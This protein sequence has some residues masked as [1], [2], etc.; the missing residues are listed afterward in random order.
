MGALGTV[1]LSTPSC[2]PPDDPDKYKPTV[3]D[4]DT[5]TA[6][7]YT[8]V[9]DVNGDC[10]GT[11]ITTRHVLTAAHCVCSE[12]AY[13]SPD[14]SD[15][16]Y[17]LDAKNKCLNAA[18]VTI[19]DREGVAQSPIATSSITVHPGFYID[20]D[21][22]HYII[23]TASGFDQ[24][25]DIAVIELASEAPMHFG[26]VPITITPPG[27]GASV[28]I[29]GFGVDTQQECLDGRGPSFGTRRV[30]TNQIS[31]IGDDLIGLVEDGKNL[32][33]PGDSGG[34]LLGTINGS[35]RLLGVTSNGSCGTQAH[36]TNVAT[37][38]G[39]INGVIA[40]TQGIV[41][42]NA[43]C[44]EGETAAT[45]CTDC[46][47]P[48]GQVCT[49]NACL[50]AADA[51]V[52]ADDGTYCGTALDAYQGAASDLISCQNGHIAWSTTC[53]AGC[54]VDPRGDDACD[55][56]G[57]T[58]QVCNDG[59]R[60]GDEECDGTD[61]AG[62]TCRS[63]GFN[64]GTLHCSSTC[65]LDKS[66]CCNNTCSTQGETQCAGTS[67]QQTCGQYDDDVCLEWGNSVQCSCRSSACSQACTDRYTLDGYVCESYTPASGT[68]DGGGE[69]FSI[70]GSVD[71]STGQMT[72]KAHKFNGTTFGSRPYQI[73][74]SGPGEAGCGPQTSV[75]KDV[76]A[77][78]A[79]IGGDSLTFQFQS[80]WL[81][82]QTQKYYCLTASTQPGDTG[83]DAESM[84]QTSWWYSRKIGL[85][86]S[87]E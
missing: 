56:G 45:C 41:C 78:V 47:C 80:N 29:V 53:S 72:I 81:E 40:S 48:G 24:L 8:F 70:C 32:T 84:Q 64:A 22:E 65:K 33:A 26:F 74:V 38:A 5:S 11:L 76:G 44:Q 39:W 15:I 49:S 75:F 54:N 36:Y 1:M 50:P 23:T 43:N 82:G 59:A 69:I 35:L 63:L 20:K 16:A 21:A 27:V 79:G 55:S 87:C 34:A 62:Q 19:Y 46:G 10:S 52:D 60:E 85:R 71:A 4:G 37:Y 25:A 61:L 13:T 9:V 17:R 58:V 30:G 77:S 66:Q 68:G 67:T 18:S 28:T 51:C 42:G 31:G 73:R 83:Y 14:N 7:F 2:S 6:G 12:Y 57:S 86:K 3:L